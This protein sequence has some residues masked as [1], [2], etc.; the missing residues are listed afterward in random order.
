MTYTE[1]QGVRYRILN[2]EDL[3]RSDEDL[4]RISIFFKGNFSN[5][6]RIAVPKTDCPYILINEWNKEGAPFWMHYGELLDG[7]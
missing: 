2:R 3:P 5:E 6:R 7:R 4:F 1:T